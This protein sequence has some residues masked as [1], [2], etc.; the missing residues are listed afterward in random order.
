MVLIFVARCFDFVLK[1]FNP[2]HRVELGLV[3]VFLAVAMVLVVSQFT[4]L[5]IERPYQNEFREL[6]ARRF[7]TWRGRG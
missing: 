1:H 6:A 2:D 3:F 5:G 4:C 7:K